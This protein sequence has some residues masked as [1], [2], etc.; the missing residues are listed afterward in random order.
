L[1]DVSDANS[2]ALASVITSLAITVAALARGRSRALLYIFLCF[3]VDIF[4]AR[5]FYTF[6]T[7]SPYNAE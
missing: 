6:A 7:T 1:V 3:F 5:P 4:V 2:V